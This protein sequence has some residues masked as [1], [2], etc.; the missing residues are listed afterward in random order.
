[1]FLLSLLLLISIGLALRLGYSPGLYSRW[2]KWLL[3]SDVTILLF[4]PL[5]YGFINSTLRLKDRDNSKYYWLHLLPT[6]LFLIHYALRVL[7]H[8]L[9]EIVSL[10]QDGIYNSFYTTFFIVGIASNLYYLMLSFRCWE[11]IDKK[12]T[13][14]STFVRVTLIFNGVTI[15]CWLTTFLIAVIWPDQYWVVNYGYQLAF[16]L[17]S[18]GAMAISYQALIGSRVLYNQDNIKKYSKSSIPEVEQK[19]WS[20]RLKQVMMKDKL[21]LQSS[22]SLEGLAKIIGLNKTQLSEIIN[23]QFDMGFADWINEY[24]VEEFIERVES[25]EFHHLT[26][27]GIAMD[28]GF[29]TKAT[30]NR[31][32]KKSKGQTPSQYF[33]NRPNIN[34]AD[35]VIR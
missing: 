35:G 12:R 4:G 10:E 26:F 34:I 23:R 14:R 5:F 2:V 30:F 28:V 3:F 18:L 27:I 22:M 21:F 17:L 33:T 25:N 20:L 13:Y 9:P 19:D 15:L 7:P 29:N 1:M 31:A 11:R 6:V 16:V 32:F 24:R 8:S